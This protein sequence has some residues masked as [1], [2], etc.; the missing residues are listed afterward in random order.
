MPFGYE[1]SNGS[2]ANPKNE[3]LYNKKELQEELGQYDY[4]ARFYDPLIARWNV[5][6]AKAEKYSSTSQYAYVSN[7]PVISIDPNG[8]EKIVVTGG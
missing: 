3:Y 6:D 4:G 5:V 1:I 8:D 2:P 7:N